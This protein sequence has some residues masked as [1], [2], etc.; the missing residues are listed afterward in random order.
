MPLTALEDADDPAVRR[1]IVPA[2]GVGRLRRHGDL[3]ALAVVDDLGH[4]VDAMPAPR[5]SNSQSCANTFATAARLLE[6]GPC[7]S[8]S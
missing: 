5:S 8:S 3:F 6:S 1:W 7:R 4:L 2:L